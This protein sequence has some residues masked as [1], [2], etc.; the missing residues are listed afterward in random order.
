M[1]VPAL[2]GRLARW[3]VLL[4]EFDI[5]YVS[6]KEVKGSAIAEF[7]ASRTSQEYE[8]I[9]FDFPD[10][11][12]M[13]I[14]IREASVSNDEYWKLTF[15]GVSNALGHGI[16]AIL[17]SSDGDHYPFT[18]RLNF[19]CTNNTTEYVACI[20]GLRAAIERKI[21]MLKVYGDSA[22][23]IYQI[24]GEWE[25]KDF[26]LVKYKK[27]VL[28]LIKEFEE[29]T[30]DYIPIEENQIA[31]A[32]ATFAVAFKYQSYPEQATEND[33]RT[34]RRMSSGYVLD[35]EVLY[36]KAL[37]QVLLRCVDT[38][39]AKSILEEVHEGICGTHANVHILVR[40]IIRFGYY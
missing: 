11:D 37:D 12:L 16:G 26:K 35:G 1:N 13:S 7:I 29:V 18:T 40:Q 9:D 31:D 38:K 5:Q 14:L 34:I 3:Q 24:K 15:D 23:V 27:L 22:L 21:N 2:S 10:E 32:L 8:P 19:D 30:F 39:E 4:S 28:K 6:Q 20:F 17:V 33:K 36:K 25:I